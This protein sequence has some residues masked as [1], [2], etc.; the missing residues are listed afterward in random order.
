MAGHSSE[1]EPPPQVTTQTRTWS[2]A[3]G[4]LVVQCRGRAVSFKGATPADGWSLEIE[5]R[6]PGRVEVTFRGNGDSESEVSVRSE[7]SGGAPVFDVEDH[8]SDDS[9]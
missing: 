3:A 2:G 1:P 6:G 7:C 8:G 5:D 4:S 9:D